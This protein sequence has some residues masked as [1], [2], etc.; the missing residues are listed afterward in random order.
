MLGRLLGLALVVVV[1]AGCGETS[2]I[3]RRVDNFTAFYN[4]FYNARKSFA[5]GVSSLEG[6]PQAISTDQFLSI[7]PAPERAGNRRDFDDAIRR[8][9]DV[10]RDHPNSRW[11]D[12]AVMLIGQSYFYQQNYPAAAQKFREA[13]ELDTRVQDDARFWL[14]R[15][16]I[17]NGELDRAA[18]HLETTLLR[19]NLDRRALPQLHL[20][21]A[22]LLV[23]QSDWAGAIDAL[24]RGLR[25]VRDREEAARGWFLLGQI[26]DHVGE[27]AEARAAF[28]R[29]TRMSPSFELDYAARVQAALAASSLGDAAES[30]EQLRRM[31]RDAKYADRR[32]Q[33]AYL[34]GRAYRILGDPDATLLTLYDVLYSGSYDANPVRGRAHYAIG[35]LFQDVYGDYLLAAA[36]YDTAATSTAA[37]QRTQTQR[38]P[39]STSSAILDA[40]QRAA[41]FRSYASVYTNIARMDSLLHL[42]TLSDDEFDAFVFER[43]QELAREIEARRRAEERARLDQQFVQQGGQQ[44]V[45][46]QPG[47]AGGAAAS[48]AG[49]LFHRDPVRVQ[50]GRLAFTRRWGERPRVPGWRRAEAVSAFQQQRD[51]EDEP[52]TIARRRDVSPQGDDLPFIDVSDV[53]RDPYLRRQMA[54]D[55]ARASYELGNVLFLTMNEADLAVD[56]YRRVL[57]EDADPAVRGRAYYALAEVMRAGGDDVQA[58]LLYHEV[59]THSEDE[60]LIARVRE[61]LGMEVPQRAD[62]ESVAQGAY[63]RAFRTWQRGDFAEA[64][65]LMMFVALEHPAT[66]SAPPALMAAAEAALEWAHRDSLSVFDPIPVSFSD[67]LLVAGGLLDETALVRGIAIGVMPDTVEVASSQELTLNRVLSHLAT[68]HSTHALADRA[69]RMLAGLQEMRPVSPDE[70]FAISEVGVPDVSQDVP[71]EDLHEEEEID[72]VVFDAAV[73][74]SGGAVSDPPSIPNTLFG[75]GPI[76]TALGGWSIVVEEHA[77]VSVAQIR[78]DEVRGEG[79]LVD[80]ATDPASPELTLVVAGHFESEESAAMAMLDESSQLPS[81]LRMVQFERT[82]DSR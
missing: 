51:A 81:V 34:R 17:V 80:I 61:Y 48:A 11:I 46:Q 21:H 35:E 41:A 31:E 37:A 44:P 30:V 26:Y 9:A 78:A 18:D 39:V 36:H 27:Y 14:A 64:Y 75:S 13:I 47:E 55:L 70:L 22:D 68:A 59:L 1:L 50:E 12:D 45:A 74:P 82:V 19:D 6:T 15:T 66:E 72:A 16:L 32:A 56:W 52:G 38:P 8:A 20:A 43:R 23:H 2:L 76:H 3:G 57:E 28:N 10:L 25:D 63:E 58:Q 54:A 49:F 24:Q 77:D 73:V 79:F 71:G 42:A 53:P 65:E 4:T 69:R 40:P 5:S 29:A 67:S 62:A 33:L 7:Y 60:E